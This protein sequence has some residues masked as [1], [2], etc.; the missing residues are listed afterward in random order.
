[1]QPKQGGTSGLGE[2]GV[3]GKARKKKVKRKRPEAVGE[4]GKTS[5][6]RKRR[7]PVEVDLSELPP[8]QGALLPLFCRKRT[9][10]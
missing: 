4:E 7:A 5:K 6:K 1:M 3:V 2:A 8:E 9:F 10:N